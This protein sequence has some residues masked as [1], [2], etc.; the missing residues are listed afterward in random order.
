M[1]YS[2]RT[3]IRQLLT[4]SV[5]AALLPAC[6]QDK[7]KASIVLKH[8]DISGED[9]KLLAAYCE[10]IIPATDTPGAKD[11]SAHLFALQMIDDCYRKDD[12]Q[13]FISALNKFDGEA[14][15]KASAAEKENILLKADGNKDDKDDQVFLYRT[16]KRLTIQAYTSS[17]FYLTKV[18]VYKLIPGKF[19]TSV[20]VTASKAN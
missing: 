16:L 1:N 11:I 12:Q 20:P 7:S 10:T 18:Q 6:L 19:I 17:E 4:V 15:M 5:G 13:R 2:R 8:L 3:A 9:E 14:F